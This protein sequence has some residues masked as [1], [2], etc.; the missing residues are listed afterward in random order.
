MNQVALITGA[1]AGIGRA[2]ALLLAQRGAA[3][4]GFDIDGAA[5]ADAVDDA[6]A[7]GGTMTAVV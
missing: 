1:A 6:Q 4:I 2:T 5:L 7:K 3:I